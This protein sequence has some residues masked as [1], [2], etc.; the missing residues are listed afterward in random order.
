[1]LTGWKE[2]TLWGG[3]LDGRI[4]A[5]PASMTRWL[6]PMMPDSLRTGT[7]EPTARIEPDYGLYIEDPDSNLWRWAPPA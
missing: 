4:V 6:V 3:P 7:L 2:A 1:M 5:V